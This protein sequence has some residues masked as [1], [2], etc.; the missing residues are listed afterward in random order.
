MRFEK[1]ASCIKFEHKTVRMLRKF[2]TGVLVFKT[3]I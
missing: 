3:R 1:V 2:I